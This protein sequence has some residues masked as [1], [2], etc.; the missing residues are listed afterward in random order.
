MPHTEHGFVEGQ[1]IE[2]LGDEINVLFADG[3]TACIRWDNVI[4]QD[5]L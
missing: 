4:S 2:E 3:S 5:N 1:K